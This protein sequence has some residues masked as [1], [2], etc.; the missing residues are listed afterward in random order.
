M[1][2]TVIRADG[3]AT[4]LRVI[5]DLW[6]IFVAAVGDEAAAK[7]EIRDLF[8][9]KSDTVLS[10]SSAARSFIKGFVCSRIQTARR[11]GL[12]N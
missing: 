10:P 8:R 11:V 6:D 1:K 4:T 9:G 5:D 3:T 7:A 12:W 2:M